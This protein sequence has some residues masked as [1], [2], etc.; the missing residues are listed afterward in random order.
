[1]LLP[2]VIAILRLCESKRLRPRIVNLRMIAPLVKRNVK[3]DEQ[4]AQMIRIVAGVGLALS[5]RVRPLRA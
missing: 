3:N 4:A 5:D 1:M 2:S